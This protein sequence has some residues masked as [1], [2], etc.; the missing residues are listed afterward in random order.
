V[1][2]N[3]LRMANSDTCRGR[4]YDSVSGCLQLALAGLQLK[5]HN[6]SRLKV[7]VFCFV[8][9]PVQQVSGGWLPLAVCYF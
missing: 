1:H 3:T 8:L 9:L 5:A 7:Q 6:E 4:N 2:T